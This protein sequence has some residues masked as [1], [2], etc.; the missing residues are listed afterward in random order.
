LEKQ[1]LKLFN[2]ALILTV[3]TA[4]I[5]ITNITPLQAATTNVCKASTSGFK[6]IQ[7]N[8]KFEKLKVDIY[9]KSRVEYKNEFNFEYVTYLFIVKENGKTIAN[10]IMEYIPVKDEDVR[11]DAAWDIYLSGCGPIKTNKSYLS[12]EPFG[13]TKSILN[14]QF[15]GK[16]KRFNMGGSVSNTNQSVNF[17]R[18]IK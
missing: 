8:K 7:S 16:L 18:F 4:T 2:F 14:F 10:L 13:D 17:F 6:K 12:V 5:G 1:S 3:L 11:N 15:N 9:R